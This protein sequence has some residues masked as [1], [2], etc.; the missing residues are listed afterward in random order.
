MKNMRIVYMGT[1]EFAVAP[2]AKLL[3]SGC[4]VVGV[5][6]VPDKPAGR[7]L[8]VRESAVKQFAVAKGLPVYQPQRLKDPQ[9][10]DQLC[11]L[12]ADLAIVVAFRMLPE[13]VWSMPRCGTF[14]LHAS[15]LPL[16]RGAAPIN[17]AIINGDRGTG[18]T[19]FMLNHQIDCGKIIGSC[20]VEIT[21]TDSAG[22]LHD[23]LMSI[24]ADLVLETVRKIASGVVQ[25]IEQIEIIDPKRMVA[26]KIFKED[27]KIDWTQDC[28]SVYNRIRGLSPYPAAWCEL[29]NKTAKIYEAHIENASH[30]LGCG[31]YECS[32][33]RSI[34]VAAKD[35]WIYIDRIQVAGGKPMSTVDFLRG[36]KI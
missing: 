24:G 5:V 28:L 14:N 23:K 17:W 9:W 7:G 36:N 35:G 31:A 30:G 27:C 20:G 19:T 13:V 33:G 8:K 16:Y 18:V 32:D 3:D 4:N 25:P 11:G 34:R 29:G 22:S 21:D 6:T 10:L 26:P 12:R 1:P 2:L 15:L